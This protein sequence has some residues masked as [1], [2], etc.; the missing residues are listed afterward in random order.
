MAQMKAMK[1]VKSGGEPMTKEGLAEALAG[2]TELK[3]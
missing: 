2:E 3:R 1:A